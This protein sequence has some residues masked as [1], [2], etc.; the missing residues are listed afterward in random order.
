MDRRV[1]I[2]CDVR[3]S[4]ITGEVEDSYLQSVEYR[5][6]G[7]AT[8]LWT[9]LPD[10]A[11]VFEDTDA[12]A[13]FCRDSPLEMFAVYFVPVADPAPPGVPVPPP[14]EPVTLA[15]DLRAMGLM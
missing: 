2:M 1:L 4:G 10:R 3:A 5:P 12:A 8:V 7:G 15:D 14:S 6:S 11:M 9:D 13:D